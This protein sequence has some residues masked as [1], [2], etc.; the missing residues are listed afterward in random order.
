MKKLLLSLAVLAGISTATVSALDSSLIFKNKTS[1]ITSDFETFGFLQID[2]LY[3]NLS[4]SIGKTGFDIAA[5][6]YLKAMYNAKDVTNFLDGSFAYAFDMDLLRLE[7]NINIGQGTL[8]I[9][10]GRFNVSD[11]TYT[12]FSQ[13]SD[14]LSI[15]YVHP[16]FSVYAFGGYTGFLNARNVIMIDDQ[17]KAYVPE[18][19][20]FYPLAYPYIM[21]DAGFS[22]SNLFGNQTIKLETLG[23]F[24]RTS[25]AANRY[26]LNTALSGPLANAYSYYFSTSFGTVNFETI[27]NYTTAKVNYALSDS[28]LIHVGVEYASGNNGFL[29]KFAG[30][31]SRTINSSS[32]YPETSGFLVPGTGISYVKNNFYTL[33]DA[34]FFIE[35]P[36]SELTPAGVE[37]DWSMLVNA[38]YDLQF[39]LDVA[40]YYDITPEHKKTN[41]MAT[42]RFVLV[43]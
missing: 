42:F 17:S 38:L 14:G 25:K 36:E 20:S 4:R 18:E 8:N 39:G 34:K 11:N 27:M 35:C 29:S 26:Y 43:F 9:K 32:A 40:G 23:F 3:L 2:E 21:Y 24:D 7:G 13:L 5:E 6:F 12:I 1:A 28:A 19:G 33:L 16:V 41:V 31:S 30:I 15:K 37:A 10:A 22:L